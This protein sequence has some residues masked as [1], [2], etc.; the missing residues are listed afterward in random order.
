MK[1][2]KERLNLFLEKL[3]VEAKKSLGQ[4]FLVS[5]IVVERIIKAVKDLKPFSLIE[6]GPGPGALTDHLL[7]MKKPIIL[8]ELDQ[9]IVLDANDEEIKY[10]EL[11]LG[12]DWVIVS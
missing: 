11:F 10:I 4:N 12:I 1:T 5:D 9:Q 3:P 8:I 2:T 6:I 7:D